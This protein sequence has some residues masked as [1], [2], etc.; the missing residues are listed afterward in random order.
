[1]S[2]TKNSP[3]RLIGCVPVLS[4]LAHKLSLNPLPSYVRR[5]RVRPATRGS[6]VF[7]D[8]PPWWPQ[9]AARRSRQEESRRP[10]A[11]SWGRV[12]TCQED[13]W[14]HHKSSNQR[15]G[16]WPAE[17][18]G[19]VVER[20][21]GEAEAHVEPEGVRLQ[22]KRLDQPGRCRGCL[23]ALRPGVGVT[24]W[25]GVLQ[26][27]IRPTERHRL[28]LH[29]TLNIRAAVRRRNPM[30]RLRSRVRSNLMSRYQWINQKCP[31][32]FPWWL[33]FSTYCV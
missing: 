30:R 28:P 5:P 6:Q 27:G 15:A 25:R 18:L 14:T 19:A 21:S 12:A 33:M 22:V 8:Q 29:E 9:P 13:V 1:M 7:P 32:S 10:P 11:P 4:W 3:C 17:E 2:S 16:D 31:C 20:F 23:G 26:N 24:A